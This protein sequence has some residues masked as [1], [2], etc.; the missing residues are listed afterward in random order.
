MRVGRCTKSFRASLIY[1]VQSQINYTI[2]EVIRMVRYGML[3]KRLYIVL[4][5]KE[6]LYLSNP[7]VACSS[8]KQT[9]TREILEDDNSIHDYPHHKKVH[10][11]EGDMKEYYSFTFVRNPFERLVSCYLNKYQGKRERGKNQGFE[12]FVKKVIRTPDFLSDRHFRSQYYLTHDYRGQK[13]V[14]F[15]GHMENIEEE[16]STI[17][18]R[19]DLGSLPHYNKNA[20]YNWMEFYTLETAQM[21][22]KR[23]CRDIQTFGY[24]NEYEQ[25]MKHLEGG[26]VSNDI[27]ANGSIQ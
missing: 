5:D 6:L 11:V 23:Y 13:R 9:M 18:S 4:M 26:K 8:I 19:F 10:K 27:S 17:R 21:V 14:Q 16:F 22:Y 24:Q 1:G 12:W 3:H 20:D 2:R 15:I 7:K 25:V